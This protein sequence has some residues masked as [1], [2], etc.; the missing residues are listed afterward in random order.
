MPK[1]L[2]VVALPCQPGAPPSRT[3]DRWDD[4]C[5]TSHMRLLFISR[6]QHRHLHRSCSP[7][8]KL[9]AVAASSCDDRATSLSLTTLQWSPPAL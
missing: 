3:C 6:P 9:G 1:V 8:R 7:Q 2:L 4:K 5:S